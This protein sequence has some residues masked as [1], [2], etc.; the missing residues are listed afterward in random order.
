MSARK[1]FSQNYLTGPVGL[2]YTT[3][4]ARSTDARMERKISMMMTSRYT[5]HTSQWQ[6]TGGKLDVCLRG[7]GLSSTIMFG[8]EPG[9][10]KATSID[11]RRTRH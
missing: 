10:R 1:V 9:R 8:G 7:L 11:N 2:P 4:A 3:Q 5:T 6:P